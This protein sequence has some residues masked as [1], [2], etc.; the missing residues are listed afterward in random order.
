MQSYRGCFLSMMGVIY[1]CAFASYYL[2]Y[3]GLLGED[4][5]LPARLHWEQIRAARLPKV[6]DASPLQIDLDLVC[7]WWT[8]GVARGMVALPKVQVAPPNKAKTL[9]AFMEFP[10]WLW[11]LVDGTPSLQVDQALEGIALLGM[12]FSALAVL[13]VHHISVFMV[14]YLN[15]LSLFLLGQRWLGFQWDIFL[16]ESG[17]L[18]LLYCPLLSL[19]SH[20]NREVPPVAWLLRAFIAKFMY[21]NGVV[22]V[23]ADCPTWKHLTALEYH[24]ASTCLPTAEAWIH[25]QLPPL[26]LRLAVAC[27]F[28]IELVLPWLLVFPVKAVRRVSVI[29]QASLQ[30]GIMISGN[31]NWFNVHTM[32]LLL[33]AWAA[34]DYGD[35]PN[36][37]ATIHRV[38]LRVARIWA[39]LWSSWAGTAAATF[40]T[41]AFIA[42]CFAAMFELRL[43]ES[44]EEVTLK[45]LLARHPFALAEDVRHVLMDDRVAIKPRFGAGEVERLSETLL[46]PRSLACFFAVV[47]ASCLRYVAAPF[48]QPPRGRSAFRIAVSSLGRLL[49]CGAVLPA[50]AICL[51]PFDMVHHGVGNN[52]PFA[53]A[54]RPLYDSLATWHVSSSYGL[55]RR[56]TGVGDAP[57]GSKGW[58]GLPP[59]VVAVPAVVLEGSDDGTSWKEIPFRYALGRTTRQPRRTAPHQPRLDWQMWFAALGSYQHNDWFI[60]LLYKVLDDSDAVHA[61]LD[62]DEAPWPRGRGGPKRVRAWLYHYDFT[63]LDTP[64]ARRIPGARLLNISDAHHHDE[65]WTRSRVREYVP[66]VSLAD[67]EDVVRRQ[68]WPA[69]TRQRQAALRRA[70]NCTAAHRRGYATGLWCDAVVAARE[71]ARPTQWR[72]GWTI[73]SGVLRRAWRGASDLF[74]IDINFVMLTVPLIILFGLRALLASVTGCCCQCAK[75]AAQPQRKVKVA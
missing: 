64:W 60:H 42:W 29:L 71:L 40:G 30:L 28:I 43:L 27:M 52:V 73:R 14:L 44:G 21:M 46:S 48:A 23:A 61:L 56:M 7:S 5:L 53:T 17:A 22:K 75:H 66:S 3:P 51:M 34:D 8:R 32:V 74:F 63:R 4:G 15:Y 57:K 59:S 58:G 13:G 9:Q 62:V 65:W 68:G 35:S 6:D 10:T 38:F 69:K 26:V 2:Q 33:P 1:F 16:L 41:C 39:K 24:F 49:L 19:L 36:H 37:G 72:T 50:L 67:L 31:Y 70:K 54:V 45:R 18:L 11:F 47:A 25:H 12:L 20:T 55:F